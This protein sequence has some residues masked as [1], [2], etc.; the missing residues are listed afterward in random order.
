MFLGTIPQ[1]EVIGIPILIIDWILLSA[2]PGL[3]LLD[4][5][6]R[7]KKQSLYAVII[8]L[9]F[10]LVALLIGYNEQIMTRIILAFVTF[11]FI[12]FIFF[13]I[14]VILALHIKK[15]TGEDF[16][17]QISKFLYGHTK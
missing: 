7:G 14:Y 16:P 15:V 5:Q 12:S 2:V 4:Y 11:G 8:I 9:V 3:F 17:I 6:I 1:F 13:I 10:I